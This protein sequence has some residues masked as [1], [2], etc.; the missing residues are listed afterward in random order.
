MTTPEKQVA[1]KF[2]GEDL[3]TQLQNHLTEVGVLSRG[4]FRRTVDVHT[5]AI[6]ADSSYRGAV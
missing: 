3:Q 6:I 5:A 4:L 2:Q 1:P